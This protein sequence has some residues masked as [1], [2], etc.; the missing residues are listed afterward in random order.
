LGLSAQGKVFLTA[1]WENLII[2]SYKVKPEILVPHM[3][4]GL[5]ADTIDGN[6]FVSLVAFDFL[7]TKVK[8]MKFPFHINFP[9]INLRFYVKNKEKRGVVFIREFVPRSMIAFF[10]NAFYNENY[11]AVKMTS[12]IEKTGKISLYHALNFKGK[13]YQIAVEAL[14]KPGMSPAGSAEHFFKEHEWGFGTSRNNEVFIYKVEHPFWKTYPITKFEHNFD[15]SAIYDKKLENLNNEV[16]Y[17]I[18]FAKGSVVKVY[19]GRMLK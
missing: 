9:E 5:E 10:A 6:A 15:F 16:P 3:P 17:N 14:D 11:R 4:P 13:R 19:N 12:K 1:R 7:D 8:G 18:T 2:I